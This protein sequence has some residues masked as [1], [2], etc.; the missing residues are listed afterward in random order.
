MRMTKRKVH[1]NF[2]GC[3]IFILFPYPID[4][5]FPDLV[6][7]LALWITETVVEENMKEGNVL[8]LAC[9]FW[10]YELSI[11]SGKCSLML[12]LNVVNRE[13]LSERRT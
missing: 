4:C 9:I 6:F 12:P 8:T 3:D 10:L 2:L 1:R 5:V 11:L 7:P 13:V